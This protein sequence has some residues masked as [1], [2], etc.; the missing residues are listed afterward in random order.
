MSNSYLSYTHTHWVVLFRCFVRYFSALLPTMTYSLL[1][2]ECKLNVN[3]R[4]KDRDGDG[5]TYVVG[6]ELVYVAG[7][8]EK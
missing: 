1:E 4:E 5:C 3:G 2:H 8:F 6:R 7:H